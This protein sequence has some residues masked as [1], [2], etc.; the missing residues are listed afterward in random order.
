MI[1]KQNKFSQCSKLLSLDI[2]PR[3]IHINIISNYTS[4]PF[5]CVSNRQ[6]HQKSLLL[7]VFFFTF[8][9]FFN[10]FITLSFHQS[11]HHNIIVFIYFLIMIIENSFFLVFSVL[12][13]NIGCLIFYLFVSD[14]VSMTTIEQLKIDKKQISIQH[15]TSHIVL[16]KQFILLIP[17]GR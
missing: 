16:C 2:C 7:Y 4:L 6:T 17:K 5:I 10:Q 14:F 9:R 8:F 12:S 1:K 15:N 13:F 3:T 11:I